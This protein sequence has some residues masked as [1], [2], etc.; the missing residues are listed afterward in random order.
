MRENDAAFWSWPFACT[1]NALFGPQSTPVGKFTFWLL[2]A[3]A[4]SSMPIFR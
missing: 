1:V 4:T 3:F 2:I